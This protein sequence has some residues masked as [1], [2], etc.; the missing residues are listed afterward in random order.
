MPYSYLE[1]EKRE[2][3]VAII[4][5]NNPESLNALGVAI[6]RAL[7]AAFRECEADPA[8]RV[9]VLRGRGRAFSAGGNLKEMRES[10]AAEPG[11]YMDELTAAVYEAI[12]ALMELDKPVIASVH[13]SAMGAAMN[14]VMACDLAVA[15]EGAVFSESFIRLGLIPGGHAT[16]LL[17]RL[18]GPKRALELC[19]TGRDVRAEEALALGLIT[20]VAPADQLEAETLKLADQLAAGPPLAIQE[21]KKLLRG[22]WERPSEVQS[23]IE[24][25]TQI[26]MA[27]TEDFKEGIEAFFAKRKPLFKGR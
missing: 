5:L 7:T 1:L 2:N 25:E 16:T 17:T 11:Q 4:T 22:Y 6:S 10:F 3:G 27:K 14:L 21:T 15:A 18:A 20:K 9:I 19:L 24:R 26:R 13:G 12:G 23:R 8:V